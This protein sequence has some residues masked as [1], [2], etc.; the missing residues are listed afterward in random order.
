[1]I[2]FVG[3]GPGAA[4]LITL[5]GA[6]RL[7]KA[8]VVIWA[9]SLIPEELL[10]HTSPNAVIHDSA[11]MTLEDVMK[12][13]LAHRDQ[14]IVR[15][16]SG[17]PGVYGAI[18]EQ[19]DRL[20]AEEIEFEIVPGVTSVAAASAILTRELT[21]PGIAQSVI[22][23]RL[24]TKTRASMPDNESIEAYARV[25][26]T[27]AVFLSGAYPRALQEAVLCEGSHYTSETPA[28]VIVR[29]T[30][31]DEEIVFTTC[32]E[33][34][35]AMTGLGARRTVLVIIG[36]ALAGTPRRSHLYNPEFA[37]TFRKRSL[38]GSSSGRPTKASRSSTH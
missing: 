21:I 20:S 35:S 27:L 6:E 18:Q 15:L 1:M 13:Y 31:P 37:H 4:D 11:A 32:G 12:I 14:P 3:A 28:A 36:A 38:S 9:S 30:W 33:L 26:G 22:F 19:I 23:T 25:G 8:E 7:S 29:A 17:D 16:H 24:A 34:A 2:S 5:R 10:R